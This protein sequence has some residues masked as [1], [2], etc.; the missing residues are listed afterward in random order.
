MGIIVINSLWNQLESLRKDMHVTVLEKGI[1]HPEV[2]VV[3]QRLD[4][5]INK[6]FI[7]DGEVLH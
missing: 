5:V 1:S 2:L 7:L 4:E 3:S 6:L